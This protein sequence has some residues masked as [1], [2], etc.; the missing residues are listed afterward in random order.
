MFEKFV[1]ISRFADKINAVKVSD[2][3]QATIRNENNK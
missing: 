3:S 2:A 1:A